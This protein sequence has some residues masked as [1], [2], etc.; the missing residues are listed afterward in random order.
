MSEVFTVEAVDLRESEDAGAVIP[1]APVTWPDGRVDI[2]PHTDQDVGPQEILQGHPVL[3]LGFVNVLAGMTSG[4]DCADLAR[5][6]SDV[7]YSRAG[8]VLGGE[9]SAHYLRGT[10]GPV[11][12]HWFD[13]I[14]NYMMPPSLPWDTL[15]LCTHYDLL[16]QVTPDEDSGYEVNLFLE[17]PDENMWGMVID[18]NHSLSETDL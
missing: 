4:Y 7:F 1:T 10:F 5:L 3:H 18:F 12:Q 14:V 8:D 16:T 11:T 15:I 2:L 9:T 17:T 6:S 13:R